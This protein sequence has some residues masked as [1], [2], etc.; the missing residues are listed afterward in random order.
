MNAIARTRIVLKWLA[1]FM[2]PVVVGMLVASRT[3]GR[4]FWTVAR[5]MLPVV[6]LWPLGGVFLAWYDIRRHQPPS[7]TADFAGAGLAQNRQ[8]DRDWEGGHV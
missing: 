4:P 5:G 1:F 8:F 3:W 6:L 2:V 7:Q